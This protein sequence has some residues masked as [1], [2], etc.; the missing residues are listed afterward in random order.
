[1]K[2]VIFGLALLSGLVSS[3]NALEISESMVGKYVGMKFP[4][5]MAGVQVTAPKVTLLEGK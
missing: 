2:N 1:M 3:S 5:S 4:K